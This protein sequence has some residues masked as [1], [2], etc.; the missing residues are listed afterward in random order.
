[1]DPNFNLRLFMDQPEYI[2]HYILKFLSLKELDNFRISNPETEGLV[3]R[4][5]EKRAKLPIN[6]RPERW[7]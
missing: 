5:I 7:M 1:M 3:L 6:A 2:Q 4:H